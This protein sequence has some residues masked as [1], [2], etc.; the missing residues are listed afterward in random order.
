M[1]ASALPIG[2]RVISLPF[3]ARTFYIGENFKKKCLKKINFSFC[4]RRDEKPGDERKKLST[5]QKITAS[6]LG[7]NDWAARF[8]R[9]IY[10][11]NPC[12]VV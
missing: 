8:F 5:G 12:G 11:H 4:N 9:I 7:G 2:Q 3:N 10:T 1:R 6:L